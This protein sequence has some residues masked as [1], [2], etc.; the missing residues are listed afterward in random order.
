M[1]KKTRPSRVVLVSSK[2]KARPLGR[3]L[4]RRF[5]PEGFEQTDRRGRY[6][7]AE[8]DGADGYDITM[9]HDFARHIKSITF[10]GPSFE[11]E[12]SS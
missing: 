1:V 12:G 2:G 3:W 10:S 7:S 5:A 11:E 4:L 6:M 9:G 8:P